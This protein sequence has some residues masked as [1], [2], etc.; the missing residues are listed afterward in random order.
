VRTK[1]LP[2][3]QAVVAIKTEPVRGRLPITP[4]GDGGSDA[5]NGERPRLG[6]VAK[7]NPADPVRRL[8]ERPT[9]AAMRVPGKSLDAELKHER[10]F[11]KRE[12]RPVTPDVTSGPSD[13]L[14]VRPTGAVKREP[15][16]A[17]TDED[18][19]RLRDSVIN[20]DTE[21]KRAVE[22]GDDTSGDTKPLPDFRRE[23]PARTDEDAQPAPE[24]RERPAVKER[25]AP[26]ERRPMPAQREERPESPRRYER[27]E[28]LDRPEPRP[29]RTEPKYERPEPRVERAPPPPREER[30]A[31][32][33][34]EERSAPPPREERSA[35][36][37]R[38]ERS[39]PPPREERS[40]PPP[41][42]ER[43]PDPPREREAPAKSSRQDPP[44][45]Q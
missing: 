3:E 39:A 25:P 19:E 8:P 34:R 22:R 21:R 41:R 31:P 38:E 4:V 20:R 44:R 5:T 1:P 29:E 13:N 24:V 6:S 43:R 26:D 11:N 16:P 15:R 9:G 12:P 45:A 14:G 36:P 10:I 27:P 42:E 30:S 17:R 28:K 18:N 33:P 2:P 35:P 40:A 37:P 23:R 7:V 32:P